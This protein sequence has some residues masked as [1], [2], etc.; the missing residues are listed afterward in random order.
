MREIGI[1][2]LEL[3]SSAWDRLG[4]G[5]L[6]HGDTRVGFDRLFDRGWARPR[7]RRP[8]RRA[9]AAPAAIRHPVRDDAGHDGGARRG[10]RPE[11]Y[12][13]MR[14]PGRAAVV[15]QRLRSSPRAWPCSMRTCKQENIYLNSTQ[16]EKIASATILIVPSMPANIL[17]R[18]FP[19]NSNFYYDAQ[20]LPTAPALPSSVA[21]MVGN[22]LSNVQ[23]IAMKPY[24]GTAISMARLRHLPG[25]IDSNGNPPP[26]QVSTAIVNNPFTPANSSYLAYQNQQT[27][28]AYGVN[29]QLGNSNI[30]DFPSAHTMA[31]T[32]NAIPYAILAPGYYQQLAMSVVDFGY[33]LNVNGCSLS[34]RRDRRANSRHLRAS[35]RRWPAIRCTRPRPSPRPISRRS[36]SDMQSYLG[37]GGSF[38]LRGGM[39]RQR[40]RRLR[41]QRHGDPHR[42]DLHPAW[43]AL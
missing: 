30:G 15:L 14:G 24:F 25:Q 4:K 12:R 17:I 10:I 13:A 38:A 8:D 2:G 41:R 16:A 43:T 37:G 29:W 40:R 19:G 35:L 20:G 18:A 6:G 9:A 26:Y 33:G 1:G 22:I 27:P 36:A 34:D 5:R 28:G 11:L 23:M 31:A 21:T 3:S 42:R 7:R 32:I 39:R